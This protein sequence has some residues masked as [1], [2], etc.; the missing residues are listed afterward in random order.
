MQSSPS[1]VGSWQPSAEQGESWEAS[2][3]RADV[4]ETTE[5]LDSQDLA[6]PSVE[7]ARSAERQVQRSQEGEEGLEKDAIVVDDSTADVDA[8]VEAEEEREPVHPAL[9]RQDHPHQEEEWHQ[10]WLRRQ[11]HRL[12]PIITLSPAVVEPAIPSTEESAV[13]EAPAADGILSKAAGCPYEG[14]EW[15]QKWLRRR[16][17]RPNDIIEIGAHLQ[18][19]QTDKESS[20]QV[21]DDVWYQKWKKAQPKRQ[22]ALRVKQVIY[23]TGD[24]PEEAASTPGDIAE[25]ACEESANAEHVAWEQKSYENEEWYQKWLRRQKNKP[26]QII[27][28]GA[29]ARR[30]ADSAESAKVE[31]EAKQA[32]STILPT[33]APPVAAEDRAAYEHEEWYQKWLRRQKNKGREI[34]E[35]G[36]KRQQDPLPSSVAESAPE[37]AREGEAAPHERTYEN[38]E[39]YQ[40]WLRRQ[41]NKNRQIIEIG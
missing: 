35:I 21:P 37:D 18:K 3:S 38:E 5:P 13:T 16:E 29:G 14:Q 33:N 34:V 20:L 9:L 30:S 23:L 8:K 31:V 41:A 4:A 24:Q 7:D 11:E 2:P 17:N 36:T 27:E 32:E 22:G 28:I 1:E 26:R 39:W 6:A 12:R 25:V 10:K 15:Y 19:T 40:K